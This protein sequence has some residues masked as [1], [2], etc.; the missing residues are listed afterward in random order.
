MSIKAYCIYNTT[1]NDLNLLYWGGFQTPDPFFALKTENKTIAFVSELEYNRCLTTSHFNEIHLLS[2]IR[3]EIKNIFPNKPFWPAFFQYLQKLYK[4]DQ[5]FI[6]DNFPASIYAQ[7]VSEISIN[8]DKTFFETQRALKNK[9]EIEEIQKACTITAKCI[10]FAKDILKQSQIKHQTLYY[11]GQILTSASLRSLIETYCLSL[12][13][14]ATDTIICGGLEASNPHARG[15][16]P[17]KANELIVIDFFPRLQS[18]HFYGDMTRTVLKGKPSYQQ[19]HLYECVLECQQ[20]II[21]KIHPGVYTNEL[22]QFAL[23][24]FEKKGYPTQDCEGFIHSL[25][26]GLGLDL[27]EYPTVSNTPIELKEGMVITIEPGLYFKNLGGVRIEDD[28]L[29]TQNGCQILS[30]C[31]YSLIL[32]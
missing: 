29:I 31:D 23:N 26:H 12:E 16:N 1:E 19:E 8:F 28:I 14:Y 27:H 4:I 10:D 17:L 11:Q 20:S 25:G 32:S 7:I 9:S 3:K 13:G 2:E 24:F 30:K 15:N 21:S 6:P 22:M 5:F 18:S